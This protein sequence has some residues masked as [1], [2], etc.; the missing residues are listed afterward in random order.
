MSLLG[1]FSLARSRSEEALRWSRELRHPHVLAHTLTFAAAYR[2]IGRSDLAA[3]EIVDELISLSIE[4]RFPYWLAA[5]NIIRGRLL[6]AGGAP[7]EGLAVARAGFADRMATGSTFYQTFY[8]ALLAE[9]CA[10]A[11]EVEEAATRLA[12]A[13]KLA[14]DTDERWFEAELHRLN[15]ELILTCSPGDCGQAEAS[16]HRAIHL[17]Q[18]QNA[19]LWELRSAVSLARLWRDQG[20]RPE[21]R[22]L[23]APVY[24][25]FTKEFDT[26]DLQ[27]ARALLRE[28]V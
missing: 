18:T 25:S 16:F 17:A 6:V 27:D 4:Q 5:A 15:G 19:K 10:G 14:E 24:D 13:L 20:K 3:L 26:P 2:L 1:Q 8:L 21:A 9:C 28:L 12:S 23:L 7:I 11:G 22:D